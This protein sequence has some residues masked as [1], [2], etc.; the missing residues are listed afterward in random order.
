MEKELVEFAIISAEHLIRIGPARLARIE[1]LWSKYS[2]SSREPTGIIK[3]IHAPILTNFIFV[4]VPFSSLVMHRVRRP[5]R[6]TSRAAGPT[7]LPPHL[8]VSLISL[9]NI[10]LLARPS[11]ASQ[12]RAAISPPP[13][14]IRRSGHLPPRA[15]ILRCSLLAPSC[16]ARGVRLLPLAV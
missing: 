6:R 2:C 11:H 14:C 3:T 12:R 1:R 4:L 8:Y 13:L 16:R 5:I 15:L 10:F 7:S 9:K